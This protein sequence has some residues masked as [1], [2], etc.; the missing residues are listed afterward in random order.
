MPARIG[1]SSTGLSRRIRGEGGTAYF[2]NVQVTDE[3]T[4]VVMP[5]TQFVPSADRQS[6]TALLRGSVT[7]AAGTRRVLGLEVAVAANEERWHE[8]TSGYFALDLGGESPRTLFGENDMVYTDTMESVPE[9]DISFDATCF[10]EMRGHEFFIRPRFADLI[11]DRGPLTVS[12]TIVGG[13]GGVAMISI[14][15]V[16]DGHEEGTMTGFLLDVNARANASLGIYF[17]PMATRC[18]LTSVDGRNLGYGNVRDTQVEF[19]NVSARVPGRSTQHFV[20]RCDLVFP[21]E[22]AR[23]MS[24]EWYEIR[25]GALHESF[26][27]RTDGDAGRIQGTLVLD[28]NRLSSMTDVVAITLRPLGRL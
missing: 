16:N 15:V 10:E 25:V 19:P 22:L 23:A 24:A 2:S 26:R 27:M 1:W 14:A 21:T 8:F 9:A 20:V 12:S 3:S 5:T 7:I 4:R 18:D 11:A 17:R 28:Q 13:A 6:G